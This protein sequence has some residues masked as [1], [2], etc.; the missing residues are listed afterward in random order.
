MCMLH[1]LLLLI[2]DGWGVGQPGPHNAISQAKLQFFPYLWN[3][4]PHTKISASGKSVGLPDHQPGNSDSGHL[5]LGTGQVFTSPAKLVDQAIANGALFSHHQLLAIANYLRQTSANLHLIGEVSQRS[6][7]AQMRHLS[8]LL[9][10]CKEQ[11]LPHVQLHAIING[12]VA[13]DIGSQY[14]LQQLQTSLDNCPDARIASITGQYW[15]NQDAVGRYRFIDLLQGNARDKQADVSACFQHWYHQGL[16]DSYIPPTAI[17]S[18]GKISYD[19][20]VLLF[21]HQGHI[22]L[23]LMIELFRAGLF[24]DPDR[25]NQ[26]ELIPHVYSL[27]EYRPDQRAHALYAPLKYRN[28]LS[29]EI[30]AN[31]ISQLKIATDTKASSAIQGFNGNRADKFYLEDTIIH[32]R[33]SL[34]QLELDPWTPGSQ[35]AGHIM[36]NLSPNTFPFILANIPFADELSHTGNF[37][38]AVTGCQVIDYYLAHIVPAA[39][40]AG[41]TTIITSDHGHAE[42][43]SA[44]QT[45]GTGGHTTSPVPWLMIPANS[46]TPIHLPNQTLTDGYRVLRQYLCN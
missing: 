24:E 38:S 21:D 3:N 13:G 19:D 15:L 32:P 14:L 26:S 12:P 10:F 17:S 22:A 39:Q 6:N 8:A 2:L 7:H 23:P 41:Y 29:A 11:E 25:P 40:R 5:T 34:S 4:Y 43:L 27:T 46:Q 33:G 36:S 31:G 18:S 44:Y 16:T 42:D 45:V 9:R 37:A 1:P 28:A 30:S 35:L 20:I